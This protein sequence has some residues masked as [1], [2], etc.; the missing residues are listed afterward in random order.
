MVFAD[1][2]PCPEALRFLEFTGNFA[3]P[4]A[5]TSKSPDA[6][7]ALPLQWRVVYRDIYPGIDRVSYRD[8]GQV[9]YNI[10]AYPQADLSRVRIIYQGLESMDLRG[11]FLG[12]QIING[13]RVAVPVN[14]CRNNDASYFLQ[15]A[16]YDPNVQLIIPTTQTPSTAV[17]ITVAAR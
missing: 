11:R 9:Q 7:P 14:M 6:M 16:P 8:P 12:Y 4:D 1:V 15:P 10:I 2:N 3:R 13:V 17:A 5:P